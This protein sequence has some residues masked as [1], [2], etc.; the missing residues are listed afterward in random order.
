MS[1]FKVYYVSKYSLLFLYRN[2]VLNNK[3]KMLE[4]FSDVF[5]SVVQ[6]HTKE[7]LDFNC[8]YIENLQKDL[9]CM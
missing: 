2:V 5:G 9:K 7:T 6:T 1:Q 4:G 8:F 3:S